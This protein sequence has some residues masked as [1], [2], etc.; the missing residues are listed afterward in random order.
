MSCSPIP[1]PKPGKCFSGGC[2]KKATHSAMIR[3][4]ETGNPASHAE[5]CK[6]CLDHYQ[7]GSKY[8]E[9]TEVT[10]LAPQPV[11]AG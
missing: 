8:F 5:V 3:V 1:A 11:S 6:G 7:G 10:P 9:V 2:R 4:I